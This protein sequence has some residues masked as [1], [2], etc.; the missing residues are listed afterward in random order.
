M[1]DAL[2]VLCHHGMQE[3]DEAPAAIKLNSMLLTGN[4]T[5]TLRHRQYEASFD[6]APLHDLLNDLSYHVCACEI[7]IAWLCIR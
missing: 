2:G 6:F 5:L 7:A 1:S 4:N 3:G